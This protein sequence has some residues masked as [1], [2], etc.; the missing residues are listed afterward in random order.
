MRRT[1]SSGGTESGQSLVE[2]ALVLPVLLLIVLGVADLGRAFY[3]S[4]AIAN[5]ARAGA[6]YAAL[7][8]STATAASVAS[9]VCNETGLVPYAPDAICSRLAITATFAP[10]TD[11][12]VSVTYRFEFLS[13][14]LVDRV[15]RI[16]PLPIRA[17]ATF[18]SL[19][20]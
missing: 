19:A 10:G 1:G 18:P 20:Q 11:A 8:P 6:V 15:F 5:A 9:K 7:N 3:Y 17:T 4:T 12:V 2:L 16:D 14:Y 13:A